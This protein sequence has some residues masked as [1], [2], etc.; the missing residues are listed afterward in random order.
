MTFGKKIEVNIYGYFENI[1]VKDQY[2]K[3]YL[4]TP[5][6][7]ISTRINI[8][9]S[10]SGTISK[11]EAVDPEWFT[12]LERMTFSMKIEVSFS[13]EFENIIVKD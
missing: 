10:L 8:L 12:P 2:C 5:Q 9:A 13:W 3:S 11:F 7:I 4:V 1:I 6:W